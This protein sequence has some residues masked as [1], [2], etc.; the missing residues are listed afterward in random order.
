[1]LTPR[2]VALGGGGSTYITDYN[3]NFYNPANLLIQ[4]RK[5]NIDFGILIAGTYFNAVQNSSNLDIQRS[6]F[7]NS[8]LA[9][10]PGS[11]GISPAERNSIIDE[12]YFNDRSTSIH[13]TRLDLTLLGFK[14]RNDTQSYSFAVR[15][16]ISSIYEVGKGWYSNEL[17]DF[18]FE[19]SLNR[20][21]NHR[22]Q[23]LTEISFGYAESFRFFSDMSP[24]LDEFNI[25]IAP[26]L[27][28]GGAYQN[29]S[30]NNVYSTNGNGN[31]I[32][33]QKFEYLASGNFSSA[34]VD[35]LNG[36]PVETALTNNITDEIFN[37]NGI[38]AGVDIGFTYLI[39]IGSDL[40]TISE[41]K[42][43]T[44]KSLRFSFS[45]TDIGF[46]HYN[47][48][49]IQLTSDLDTSL[50]TNYPTNLSNDAFVGAPGQF[51]DFTETNSI[52]NP[53]ASANRTEGNLSVLLPTALHG[54]M[55][56]EI[57]RIKLMGD[58]SLGLTDNAFNTRK[59]VTSLGIELR[60]IIFL[61]L[62]A[63]TQFAPNLPSYFSFGTAIETKLWDL[64]IATQFV[65]KS[66]SDNPT[67]TGVTVAALQFH[68]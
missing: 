35:Y 25:G 45:I 16:R 21:L 58:F 66:F 59:L 18:G 30:W 27:V 49:G 44:R 9:F 29:A 43:Q 3:A 68:F 67:I 56:F 10:T 23:S 52:S 11:Y 55:L 47:Q 39:T 26:K 51:I 50:V 5:K 20:T 60:P 24:R 37:P 63:G 12:N 22:Y 41:N 61:P 1:M 31:I 46:V 2:N 7:E 65:S 8:L 33:T 32:S 13:Q 34:T 38:G 36:S 15:N 57:N 17:Q 4:D 40:S 53:F 48:N 54:G 6:N 19:Q 62:R 64:S 42:Q 28:F 14:W